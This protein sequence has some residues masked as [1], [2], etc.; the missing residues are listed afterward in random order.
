MNKEYHEIQHEEVLGEAVFTSYD[1]LSAEGNGALS[2]LTRNAKVV[3][4]R[5]KEIL[6]F[7]PSY[8][9]QNCAYFIQIVQINDNNYWII[10]II[11]KIND[12]NKREGILGACICMKDVSI[13]R[14]GEIR[15]LE[16][17]YQKIS[18]EYDSKWRGKPLPTTASLGVIST[19]NS[20]NLEFNYRNS[21]KSEILRISDEVGL[22]EV[23][24][25]MAG[26][27]SVTRDLGRVF[28]TPLGEGKLQA[29]DR[30]YTQNI[31][32]LERKAQERAYVREQENKRL[33]AER[34]RREEEQTRFEKLAQNAGVD[35]RKEFRQNLV[36]RIKQQDGQIKD[37]IQRVGRLEAKLGTKKNRATSNA[38][39]EPGA[40]REPSRTSTS[41]ANAIKWVMRN[42]LLFIIVSAMSVAAISLIIAISIGYS[43]IPDRVGSTGADP[44][45]AALE[46][47]HRRTAT[48]P[49]SSDKPT[50]GKLVCLADDFA[51]AV[52]RQKCLDQNR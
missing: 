8:L 9:S 37:L 43:N 16:E 10:G 44:Q 2:F 45:R 36:Q 52:E 6:H 28:L 50:L 26:R 14:K 5:D 31:Q 47:K 18:Q 24:G 3:E 22:E 19:G 21:G 51:T 30:N 17:L 23:F 15:Y 40:P 12:F 32:K 49:E 25:W 7:T 38:L 48:T 33:E 1:G 29:L 46:K 34:A 4:M 35:G 42:P 13:V 39:R 41:I 27:I 11:Q 20:T